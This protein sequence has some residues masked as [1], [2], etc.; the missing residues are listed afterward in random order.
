M[1]V[2]E[3]LHRLDRQGAKRFLATVA[4][5]WKHLVY[6]LVSEPSYETIDELL[7]NAE[8][9]DSPIDAGAESQLLSVPEAHIDDSHDPRY[10]ATRAIDLI[11]D[12]ALAQDGSDPRELVVSCA[13]GA[14]A[15]AADLDSVVS[16]ARHASLGLEGS[17]LTAQLEALKRIQGVVIAGDTAESHFR[18]L[19]AA[20]HAAIL[21]TT[22]T[23]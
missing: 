7:R 23:P 15:L 20:V 5:R 4:H 17:E 8:T 16:A 2:A 21:A 11:R 1:D 14:A 10:Y 22:S 3:R 18:D 12:L 9:N 13:E 6:F 19:L